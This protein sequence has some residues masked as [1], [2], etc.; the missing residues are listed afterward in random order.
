MPTPRSLLFLAI[1]TGAL[2]AGIGVALLGR[3][4]PAPETWAASTVLDRPRAL[5]EFQL[6]TASGPLTAADLRGRW[7]LVFFGFA[8]CPDICPTTL[9]LLAQVD[10]SLADLPAAARPQVL[11]VSVDP[12]RDTPQAASEYAAFFAAGFRGATGTLAELDRLASALGAP[13]L[14]VPL[15]PEGYTV[16]HSGAVFVLDPEV[17]FAAV[18][19]PP[20]VALHMADDLRRLVTR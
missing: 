18:M 10:R 17:R 16:D 14:K 13:F 11:F 1:A 15:G 5:P 8:A 12:E 19:T 20:L 2:A 7:T 3:E 6:A 9:A 4:A